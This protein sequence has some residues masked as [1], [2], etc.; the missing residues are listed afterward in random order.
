MR[1]YGL[2]L[3]G[4]VA[5]AMAVA[6]PA[7]AAPGTIK[8]NGLDYV[9]PSGCVNVAPVSMNLEIHNDTSGS[10]TVYSGADCQGDVTG[11]VNQG[12]TNTFPGASVFAS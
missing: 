9:D 6:A 7:A 10:I 1:Q 2:V 4:L 5:L 12:S 11:T 3:P 8:V